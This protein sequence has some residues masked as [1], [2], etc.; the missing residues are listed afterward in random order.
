MLS[1]EIEDKSIETIFL[2]QFNSDKTRFVQFIKDNFTLFVNQNRDLQN[3]ELDLKNLQIK[4][5]SDTWNSDKDEAWD[6]L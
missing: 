1:L 4:S 5:M 6:E 2:E 3:S